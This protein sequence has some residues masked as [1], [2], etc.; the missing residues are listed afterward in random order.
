[1]KIV[2]PLINIT[3]N[4]IF[5]AN[6]NSFMI[7]LE[8]DRW[9]VVDLCKSYL[10][11]HDIYQYV[12]VYHD[13]VCFDFNTILVRQSPKDAY[14]QFIKLEITSNTYTLTKH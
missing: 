5:I 9:I 14:W 7:E 8:I 11:Y 6:E 12:P 4:F 2:M 1:M 10:S 3:I 13:I